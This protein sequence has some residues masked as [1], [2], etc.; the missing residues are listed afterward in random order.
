MKNRM[1][2]QELEDALREAEMLEMGK[3]VSTKESMWATAMRL[4]KQREESLQDA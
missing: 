4:L 3:M 1:L 2:M